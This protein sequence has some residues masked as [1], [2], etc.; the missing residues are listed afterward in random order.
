LDEI[1]VRKWLPK[2]TGT[3][4]VVQVGV[5]RENE[6]GPVR[7]REMTWT[8]GGR[9]QDPKSLKKGLNE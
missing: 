3:V 1:V 5:S 8:G 7:G 4:T 6:G 2:V 9:E